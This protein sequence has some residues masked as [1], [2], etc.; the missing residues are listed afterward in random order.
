M[1]VETILLT[2]KRDDGDRLDYMTEEA[3]DLATQTG[4]DVVVAHVFESQSSVNESLSRLEGVD[5]TPTDV[6]RRLGSVRRAT[7]AM[8]AAGVEFRV[9]GVVGDPGEAIA[10]LATR[11]DADRV[12]VGGRKRSPTGKAV[13]GSTAQQILLSAPCPVTFIRE[14]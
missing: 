9:E 3:I 12:F 1:S 13:F 6:A 4:A 2:V 5:G 7:K 8:E 14:E 10:D 11:V